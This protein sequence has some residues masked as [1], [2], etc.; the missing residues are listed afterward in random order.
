[1]IAQLRTTMELAKHHQLRT[2]G[3]WIACIN[4]K[5]FYPPQGDQVDKAACTG[6]DEDSK[7]EQE[8]KRLNWNFFKFF[9]KDPGDFFN[10]KKLF[11]KNFARIVWVF[12]DCVVVT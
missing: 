9:E 6:F 7:S 2:E 10:K 4:K 11:Y 5:K 1:M 12:L 3:K 8:K